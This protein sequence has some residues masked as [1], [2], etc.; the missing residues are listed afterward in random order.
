MDIDIDTAIKSLKING[1]IVHT[2]IF[3]YYQYAQISSYDF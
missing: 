1:K 3:S 2:P